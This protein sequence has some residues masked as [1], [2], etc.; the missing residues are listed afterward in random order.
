MF[1]GCMI[2]LAFAGIDN[3]EILKVY[4]GGGANPDGHHSGDLYVTIK[5]LR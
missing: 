3:N 4:G 5:V 2:F 1:Q